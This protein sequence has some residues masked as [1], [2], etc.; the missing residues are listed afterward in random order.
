[1]AIIN[2]GFNL[3]D[4]PAGAENVQIG[5]T[6]NP[7]FHKFTGNDEPH[8]D[9]GKPI[10]GPFILVTWETYVGKCLI[11]REI[12]GYNDS[13]FTMLVW[14]EKEERPRTITFASTR[15]WSYPAYGSY[16]DATP[17]VREKYHAYLDQQAA[18][19]KRRRE[20]EAAMLRDLRL[21]LCERYAEDY[22]FRAARLASLI[23]K[24]YFADVIAL[25]GP[26]IRSQFKRSL[27]DQVIAWCQKA[28]PKYPDPLSKRQLSYIQTKEY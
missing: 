3:K 7:T 17:E 15:G 5:L 11:D 21:N 13:D 24:P 8:P 12:N 19:A 23:D 1:M 25:F 26:R 28:D 14:D 10:Q 20:Y 9:E 27:R 16:V 22:G 18:E 4:I 2:F 6:N